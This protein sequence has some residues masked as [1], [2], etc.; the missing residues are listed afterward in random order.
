MANKLRECQVQKPH[1]ASKVQCEFAHGS[2][3]R[4]GRCRQWVPK[5]KSRKAR[6]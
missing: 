3:E 1:Y 2:A 5:G 4:C 6:R